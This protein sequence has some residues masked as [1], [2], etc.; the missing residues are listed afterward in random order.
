M[1]AIRSKSI[2][3]WRFLRSP[4]CALACLILLIPGALAWN[5]DTSD[6]FGSC[7]DGTWVVT[8]DVWGAASNWQQR[9]CSDSHSHWQVVANLKGR[10]W[11]GSYPH[12]DY[13]VNQALKDVLSSSAPLMGA[14]DASYPKSDKFDFAY[15][16]WLNG[17]TYEVMIWL[18]WDK[19]APIGGSPFTN[20]I[21]DGLTYDVYEGAGGSGPHCISFLPRN[22]MMDT[23]TNFNLCSILAWIDTLKWSGGPGGAY[24]QNP[25]FNSVQLGWEICDTFGSATTYTMNYF[26]VYYGKTN[27]AA[28]ALTM[29]Q[30]IWQANFDNAFPSGA[31]YGFSARDGAPAATGVLS[32]NRLGGVSN[33][34]AIAYTVD[35]SPWSSSPPV[36]YSGFGV[37]ANQIPL[38]NPLTS[39]DQ[40]S[41]RIYFSAKVRGARAG[42]TNVPG[43][44]DLTFFVPTGALIPSNAAPTAVFDLTTSLA[45]STN[46][47]S[48]KFDGTDMQ[49]ASYLN[50]AQ[51]LF[52]QYVAQVNQMQLQVAVQGRP[53]VGALF[54][55]D[56]N[57]AVEIGNIKVMQMVPG[58]LRSE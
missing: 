52:G 42:V 17:T 55:Y 41:Y 24:W 13:P 5:C 14:W 29:E 51:S 50:G 44:V 27:T 20:A 37:G 31:G 19:T 30:P 4:L 28:P 15:D 40:A 38:P 22:G 57:C 23:G 34:A 2:P 21:I 43:S 6:Q 45:L 49:I 32:T 48:Y 12:A 58:V 47:Q 26:N 36:S 8:Q 53:D 35:L 46:W 39:A 9:L 10:Q 16:L 25:K 3:G 7:V 54:G 1:N 18:N 11:V 33:N 56:G